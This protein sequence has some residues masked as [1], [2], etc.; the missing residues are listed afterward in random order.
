MVEVSSEIRRLKHWL[1]SWLPGGIGK[2]NT[3]WYRMLSRANTDQSFDKALATLNK[4]SICIDL[5]ANVGKYTKK[6]ARLSGKVYAFEPDPWTFSRLTDATKHLANVECIQAAVGAK[7]GE[8]NIYRE[9]GFEEHSEHL[10]VATSIYPNKSRI[11]PNSSITV[12]LIDIRR[13]IAELDQD[14]AIIKIDIEGAEVPLLE[15]L[16]ASN[17]LDRI[18]YIFAET[19]EFLIPELEERTDA[20]FRQARRIRRPKINLFWN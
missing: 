16:L 14:I 20:L 8:I 9:T 3:Y 11:D 1:F 15:G 13:F 5:G 6:L 2:R 7:D 17:V 10:S 4:N 12:P 19:H 18:D